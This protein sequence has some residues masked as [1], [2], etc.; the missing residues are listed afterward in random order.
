MKTYDNTI[1]IIKLDKTSPQNYEVH[2]GLIKRNIVRTKTVR[3]W[4]ENWRRE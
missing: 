3:N 2:A 4:D 1:T